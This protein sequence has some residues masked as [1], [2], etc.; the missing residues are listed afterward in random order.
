MGL[1]I[2]IRSVI[3][4][5]ERYEGHIMA[6]NKD[7]FE[8]LIDECIN[9]FGIAYNDTTAL[10]AT[11]VIGKDRVLVIDNPRYQRET[12]KLRAQRTLN[13]LQE[14]NNLIVDCNKM[15]E[16]ELVEEEETVVPDEAPNEVLKADEED[17]GPDDTYDVRNKKSGRDKKE[18]AKKPIE[19]PKQPKSPKPPKLLVTNKFDK[20]K[21][22]IKIRLIQQRREIL[23]A[24]KGGEE[25][26]TDALNI[27]FIPVTK[28]EFEK[29]D[30]VEALEATENTSDPYAQG[31][32][33]DA[34]RAIGEGVLKATKKR[35]STAYHY[36]EEADGE[37]ILVED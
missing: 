27:F 9:A 17:L 37:K 4:Y 21:F 35:S 36:E 32:T 2:D 28:E 8:E 24:S 29:I 34:E 1:F 7:P 30:T 22:D 23:D 33:V 20:G 12:R 3:T 31:S 18:K 13:D 11:G 19:A 5:Y 15:P 16:E 10:D 14:I 26:E 25:K 6:K